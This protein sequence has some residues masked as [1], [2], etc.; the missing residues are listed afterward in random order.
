MFKRPDVLT[1][2]GF[3]GGCQSER[4]MNPRCGRLFVRLSVI[5]PTRLPRPTVEVTGLGEQG[6]EGTAQ[7]AAQLSHYR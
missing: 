3:H 5:L 7:N 2:P 6:P 4:L 1:H